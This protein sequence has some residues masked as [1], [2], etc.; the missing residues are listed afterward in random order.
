MRDLL[1]LS[2]AA[3]LGYLAYR[4]W[5]SGTSVA[6]TPGT[7]A[8]S[9]APA[10]TQVLAQSVARATL[11]ARASTRTAGS[12]PIPAAVVAALKT[13]PPQVTRALHIL[14]F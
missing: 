1:L 13:S 11:R 2:V 10:T 6:V 5:V 4:I 7:G 9:A 14:E 12:E 8:S 3:G